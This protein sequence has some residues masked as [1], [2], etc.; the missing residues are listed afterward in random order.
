M[1]N[2]DTH[3]V[4]KIRKVNDFQDPSVSNFLGY[5]EGHVLFITE[6]DH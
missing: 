5:G 2:N 4:F 3:E 6:K 1:L